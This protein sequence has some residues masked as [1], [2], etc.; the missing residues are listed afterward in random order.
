MT[1]TGKALNIRGKQRVNSVPSVCV[2]SVW[3]VG[4][5]RRDFLGQHT[6]LFSCIA[7][8][9]ESLLSHHKGDLPCFHR[10][11]PALS[12]RAFDREQPAD[13][14][15]SGPADWLPHWP[16]CMRRYDDS[17]SQATFLQYNW[18]V[19]GN[20]SGTNVHWL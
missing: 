5:Q 4:C 9:T 7:E 20:G 2:L 13:T 11:I 12:L 14:E 17:H 8:K 1:L 18:R 10:Q 15:S 16:I 19:A 6:D 3:G